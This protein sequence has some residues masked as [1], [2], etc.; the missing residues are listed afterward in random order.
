MKKLLT[1]IVLTVPFLAQ[2][3]E[4]QEFGSKP[5]ENERIFFINQSH[6]NMTSETLF[7]VR[8]N[9][10]MH[11]KALKHSDWGYFTESDKL[12]VFDLGVKVVYFP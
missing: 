10:L 12:E 6:D 5:V 8:Y 9:E 11:K 3:L 4:W 7:I 2:S 1:A